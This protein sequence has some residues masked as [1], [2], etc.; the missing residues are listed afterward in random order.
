MITS[1]TIFSDV[2]STS[3]EY[4]IATSGITQQGAANEWVYNLTTST[5]SCYNSGIIYKN[6]FIDYLIV[7]ITLLTIGG[8]YFMLKK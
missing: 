7:V 1:S 3:Y 6:F 4:Q 5:Q 2:C 8:I